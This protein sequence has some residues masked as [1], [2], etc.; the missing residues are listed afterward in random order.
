MRSGDKL[1]IVTRDDLPPAQ[2][3][4]QAIHAAR[5]FAAEYAETE[6]TWFAESNYVALLSVPS[7][8]EMHEL[9]EQA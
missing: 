2:Q 1:Y 8:K 4:V 9:L 7:E 6:A 5:Q 3:A